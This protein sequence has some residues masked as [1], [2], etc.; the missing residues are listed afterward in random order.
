MTDVVSRFERRIDRINVFFGLGIPVGLTTLC[1]LFMWIFAPEYFQPRSFAIWLII[2]ISLILV[3][4]IHVV[5]LGKLKRSALR[6][7]YGYY[8]VALMAFSYFVAPYISPFSFLWVVTAVG[9][10]LLFGR[11]WVWAT[12]LLY[13]LT[14]TATFFKTSQPTTASVILNSLAQFVGI[15][16]ISLLIS[17]YRQVSDDER[18]AL[19]T[20]SRMGDFE[21]QRL[22]SLIN[23][24]G[25]AVIATDQKGKI[26]LYNAAVLEMLD[27]N[28]SLD[29]KLLDSVIDLR[30]KK[31]KKVSLLELAQKS[32]V[33]FTSTDYTHEFGP[34]DNIKL[35]VNISPIKLG[36]KERSQSGYIVI[37]RDITKEK[38][39]EEERDEFISVVSHELRTPVAIAEGNISNARYISTQN[40]VPAL[41]SDSLKQAHDQVLFLAS[42]IND[43]STLSR[44]ER[45]D[46]P[47]EIT[48]VNPK[49]LIHALSRDY[50]AEAATKKLKLTATAAPDTKV[51]HTAEL[52]LHEILQNFITNAI[53]YTREGSVL[54]NVRSDTAGNAVFS[55]AD[56]GIGLSKADQKRVFEKFFRSEDYRTRESSGTGL[57]LYVTA[58]LAKRLNATISLE[59]E[60]NK[61]TTFTISVPSLE[62]VRTK[63]ARE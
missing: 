56:T 8:H 17:R 62:D 36:Y 61:G 41:I 19:D 51:I 63:R 46:R 52:Y 6:L 37:L 38:S 35:Y 27:T 30:N 24:M 9:M 1:V 22:L 12:F 23:N 53:K 13:N 47:L 3:F 28:R 20:S 60:L 4:S 48:A 14:M 59:S 45:T 11:K 34:D 50:E 44:A 54:I 40:K 21:R 42:M 32:N 18:K 7:I 31:N 15:M 43:L 26:L 29:G 2:I 49:D 55:V 39:L 57:G 58:K 25:E 33:S 5:R 16:G 10:D